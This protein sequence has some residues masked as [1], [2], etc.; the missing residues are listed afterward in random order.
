MSSEV[1]PPTGDAGVDEEAGEGGSIFQHGGSQQLPEGGDT[2]GLAFHG[3]PAA[4][5]MTTA[6]AQ[7]EEEE[8]VFRA[9]GQSMRRALCVPLLVPSC[10]ML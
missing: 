2:G 7:E 5:G 8:G 3:F 10:R 1:T 9:G 6:A 4:G